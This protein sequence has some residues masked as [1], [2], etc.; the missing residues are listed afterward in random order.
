LINPTLAPTI[1]TKNTKLHM[2][3][4]ADLCLWKTKYATIALNM[5]EMNRNID[6]DVFRYFSGNNG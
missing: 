1:N 4:V 5:K 6:V 3:R 2:D